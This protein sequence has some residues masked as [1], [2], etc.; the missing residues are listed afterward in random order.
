[1]ASGRSRPWS[2]RDASW[3]PETTP[4]AGALREPTWRAPALT[5]LRVSFYIRFLS[6]LLMILSN[7]LR[8][9]SKITCF[10]GICPL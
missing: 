4:E 2:F 1:M 9:L 10:K 7:G 5:A 8:F 3:D 6:W